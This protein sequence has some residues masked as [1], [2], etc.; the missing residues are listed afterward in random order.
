MNRSQSIEGCILTFSSDGE[1]RLDD[2]AVLKDVQRFMSGGKGSAVLN[3]FSYA[4]HEGVVQ[5][6]LRWA[7]VRRFPV[8]GKSQDD[9]DFSE[10]VLLEEEYSTV[11]EASK[12]SR[13][14]VIMYTSSG[15]KLPETIVVP[16]LSQPPIWMVVDSWHLSLVS[17]RG[18]QILANLKP[19]SAPYSEL[20]NWFEESTPRC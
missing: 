2:A 9:T 18:E 3:P 1:L 10:Y 6:M 8:L 14:D 4:T 20:V 5:G 15:T 12:N 7:D 11:E 19:L 16:A 17:R 13:V